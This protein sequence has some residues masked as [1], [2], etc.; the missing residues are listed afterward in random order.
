MESREQMILGWRNHGEAEKL[1]RRQSSDTMERKLPED[2][3]IWREVWDMMTVQWRKDVEVAL[4]EAAKD[5][6]PLM[7]DFSASPD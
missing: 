4:A 2:I 5:N 1:R 7:I 3:S 6:R